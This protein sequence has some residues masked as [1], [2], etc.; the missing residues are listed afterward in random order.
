MTI[1]ETAPRT[2]VTERVKP[3]G[4]SRW[5]RAVL[6]LGI[7]AY[8]EPDIQWACA[9]VLRRDRVSRTHST[10]GQKSGLT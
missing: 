10:H 6:M 8:E 1:A 9:E 2:R 7:G 5:E 4:I 3:T